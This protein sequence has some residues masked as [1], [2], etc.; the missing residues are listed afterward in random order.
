MNENILSET[1]FN[2]RKET[3]TQRSLLAK[4]LA[5]PDYLVEDLLTTPGLAVLAGKK[6][7]GKSWMTLQLAQCVASGKPFLGK[8]T[9][10]GSV[11]YLALEDGERRLKQRLESQGANHKLPIRYSHWWPPINDYEGFKALAE[12][13]REKTPA[14]V[15]IDTLASARDKRVKENESDSMGDL[16]NAVHELAITTNTVILIVAHHG[17][18]PHEDP[19]FD[20]RGSSAIAGATDTN[21]G[22]YK[23]NDV[24]CSLK[25][26]GRDILEVDLRVKF[27]AEITWTWQCQGDNRD[28]RRVEAETRILEAIESLG[29]AYALDIAKELGI[30]R[31]TVYTHLKRMRTEKRVECK[32]VKKSTG[33][34][35]LY[36]LPHRIGATS[37]TR[38]PSEP[39]RKSRPGKGSR[40]LG[41]V[42]PESRLAKN[43]ALNDEDDIADEEVAEFIELLQDAPYG[44]ITH[45]IFDWADRGIRN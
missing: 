24:S 41:K 43:Q 28:I 10:Q 7:L 39:V 20:I 38:L 1:E 35:I 34:K 17:K 33:A 16:F 9:R 27:D 32:T 29:E 44:D 4:K 15:V 13:I 36:K 18:K 11:L 30:A 31:P 14:L 19:G 5:P 2:W 3:I 45:L 23:N 8:A 40:R 37:P 26:E 12:I 25:A 42:G 22:L 6:K 21:I